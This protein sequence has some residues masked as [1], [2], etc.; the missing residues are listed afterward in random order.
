MDKALLKKKILLA[1]GGQ[2][3]QIH[4]NHLLIILLGLPFFIGLV[5]LMY[6]SFSGF[7]TQ[8]PEILKLCNTQS[9]KCINIHG[10][11]MPTWFVLRS[12]V[13]F[14]SF[15]VYFPMRLA[16]HKEN[17]KLWWCFYVLYGYTFILTASSFFAGWMYFVPLRLM[18]WASLAEVLLLLGIL[19]QRFWK[20]YSYPVME[21][22]NK[23]GILLTVFSGGL[24]FIGVA[25]GRIL[26]KNGGIDIGMLL[27]GVFYFPIMVITVNEWNKRI[28][29]SNPW[30]LKK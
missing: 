28:W 27:I 6:A 29:A 13:M 11:W 23:V 5:I 9:L 4:T 20:L 22:L 1:R 30:L 8:Y 3:I 15:I 25:I 16:F 17:W 14:I 26:A 24:T 18:P 12:G 2:H 21:Y 19:T 10:T 7:L